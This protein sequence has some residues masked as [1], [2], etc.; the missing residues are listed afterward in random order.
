M[1][2][3]SCE[4]VLYADM[5]IA[6]A[7]QRK[8]EGGKA[9]TWRW[10]GEIRAPAPGTAGCVQFIRESG[11]LTRQR[12]RWWCMWRPNDNSHAVARRRRRRIHLVA[13]ARFVNLTYYGVPGADRSASQ[14]FYGTV[15]SVRKCSKP[16]SLFRLSVKRL[17]AA[18]RYS[19]YTR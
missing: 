6:T 5:M 9:C 17:A 18:S 7:V 14:V 10:M 1:F 2:S 11:V 4:E 13:M 12:G 16:I 19:R 3:G 8:G 15:N